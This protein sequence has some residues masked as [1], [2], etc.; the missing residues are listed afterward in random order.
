M[1]AL[2]LAAVVALLATT[3]AG[4]R[5]H[6][7][8][9]L[10]VTRVR[11]LHYGDAL[12]YFYQDEDFEALTRLL[13]YEQWNRLPHH[14]DEARLLAGGLFLSLGMHNEAGERFASLLTDD[15]PTGVRNRA[16]YY[17]AQ[18][19]YARGYLDKADA[20]LRKINGRMSADL[21]AQ[22]E[23]LFG[24]VLMHEGHD[25]E[26]IRLLSNWRGGPI[27]SAYA[28]FNLGVA[29]VRGGRLADADPFLTGV[30]TMLADTPELAALRDRANLALGFAYLQANKPA[31]ALPALARVRL[32]G[33]YSNKALL[34]TGWA[35][36]ALGDYQRA[37]TP[38][39]ELRRRDV[40]DAAVQEAY[41]AVPF[42][43]GKLNANAQSAEYY[44]GAMQGFAA[45]NG[46]LDDAIARITHG[47]MLQQVLASDQDAR[48]GWFWQLKNLPDAPESRYLYTVLAG[49]DFQEGLKNYR[50]LVKM[51]SSL[52]R[53]DES[54]DAFQDMIS[55]RA[56]AYAER[57]PRADALLASGAVEKLQQR[58]VALES[59]LRTIEAQHDVAALGTAAER[60]QWARVQRV[61]AALASA[62]D[63][64]E[65]AEL[66]TRLTLVKGVL[67]YGLN[68][69][70]AARLWQEHRGLKDLNLALHE[71]QSRWIRVERDRKSVPTNTEEFAARVA[72]LKQRIDQLQARLASTE[73]KQS[74]YL[75]RVATSELQ[76]QKE[77]LATYQ[78]QARFALAS[79]YDRAANADAARAKPPAPVQKGAADEP[80]PPPEAPAAPEGTTPPAPPPE[81]APPAA[82]PEAAPPTPPEGAPPMPPESPPPA[83][84]QEGAP[85]ESAPPT[86]PENPPATPSEPPR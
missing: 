40:L 27:W 21:E 81:E 66:R 26:A 29:L 25:D 68:D 71:A 57:L 30:G 5:R 58:D 62:P 67:K 46:K 35:D 74:A 17:L 15:V 19:W 83:A 59:E 56:H 60:E 75:A 47:D 49:H 55:T 13:A 52:G 7:P 28:R 64:P 12:F 9:K 38:W 76:A 84:P 36:A 48:Y 50:D 31:Q 32:N 41:L 20:A 69:A 72:A 34:G 23:L 1:R 42:A 77:R 61:E 8:E 54:M 79:M 14:Q 4:A 10:P 80:A 22:K 39:M 37:L 85:P 73:Q 53:W 2:L 16:W 44:E 45:E 18:V 24:N 51:N 43:F 82:P 78:V 6:D 3:P 65:N 70:F 86:P 63:T 33:P 11:D